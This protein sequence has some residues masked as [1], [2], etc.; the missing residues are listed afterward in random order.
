MA[1]AGR[2]ATHTAYLLP[3]GRFPALARRHHMHGTPR[4]LHLT[5]R[6]S[7]ITVGRTSYYR[8]SDILDALPARDR[9]RYA[10]MTATTASILGLVPMGGRR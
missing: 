3:T 8:W 10:P 5:Q 6:L 1:A 7:P 2:T 9:G 4:T